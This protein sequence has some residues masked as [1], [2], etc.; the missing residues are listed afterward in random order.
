[1]ILDDQRPL[2][3][4]WA[5][6]VFSDERALKYVDGIGIHWYA[7]EIFVVPFALDQAHEE[8][9]D[10]FLLYTEGPS[11]FYYP[12]S[13]S[14]LSKFHTNFIQILSPFYF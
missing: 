11:M 2:V 7:D 4:K 1:M 12:N 5:R 14:I 10:K 9:P 8:F 6:E 13:I 3:P